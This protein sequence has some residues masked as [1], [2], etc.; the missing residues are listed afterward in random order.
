[1]GIEKYIAIIIT[2]ASQEMVRSEKFLLLVEVNLILMFIG[3]RQR[4]STI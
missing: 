3:W 2:E 4:I 1:M